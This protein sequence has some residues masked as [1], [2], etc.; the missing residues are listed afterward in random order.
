MKELVIIH[1]Y[2]NLT[3]NPD[4]LDDADPINSFTYHF[5][6]LFKDNCTICKLT[7][8]KFHL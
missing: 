7:H 2:S 6:L 3:I 4:A 5:I 8:D 1:I